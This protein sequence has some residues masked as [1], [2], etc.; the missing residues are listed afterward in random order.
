MVADPNGP[1]RLPCTNTG[2][3]MTNLTETEERV[4]R[5]V[6]SVRLLFAGSSRFPGAN[7]AKSF[8][9]I[10][11]EELPTPDLFAMAARGLLKRTGQGL[12]AATESGLGALKAAES[13]SRMDAAFRT[14]ASDTS[15][16]DEWI[17]PQPTG[18]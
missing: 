6:N 8:A 3:C 13:R 18:K 2:L 16:T 5:Y 1:A 11:R 14:S 15:K 7:E 17:V 4:I 12:W 10:A 9:A